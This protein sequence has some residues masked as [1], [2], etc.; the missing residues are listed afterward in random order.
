MG[1]EPYLVASSLETVLAQRLVRL[2][3]PD[4]RQEAPPSDAQRAQLNGMAPMKLYRGTGCR[5]CQ[6]TGYH[7]RTGIF[8]AMPITEPI[9]AMILERASA[10]QIRRLAA[11]QGMRSLR[12]DGWRLI[13]AG[14]TTL[15]EVLRATKDESF[16][17]NGPGDAG[18]SADAQQGSS[19]QEGQPA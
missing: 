4:C 7:G 2:I 18:R 8:E 3:C 1:I 9:R 12:E 15:E 6:G 16:N 17:G 11:Q 10:G 5:S 14:L 13:Q 19:G